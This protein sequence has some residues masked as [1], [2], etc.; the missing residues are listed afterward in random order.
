MDE[1][2]KIEYQELGQ[3]FRQYTTFLI[4][5]MQHFIAGN[6]LFFIGLTFITKDGFKPSFTLLLIVLLG[7]LGSL[8]TLIVQIRTFNY[9]RSLLDRGA[10][11]ETTFSG[12]LYK[13]FQNTSKKIKIRS[14]H[15]AIFVY[16]VF[17]I[18]WFLVLL[19]AYGMT[20]ISITL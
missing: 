8:G 9:W 15:F 3:L 1:K 2:V 4:S 16:S 7:F 18:F 17:A 6:G 12:E 5:I 19:K 13:V 20:A 10:S 11:L 14:A